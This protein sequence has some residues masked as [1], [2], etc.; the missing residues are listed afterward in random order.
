MATSGGMGHD[1]S[2]L[3]MDHADILFGNDS[4]DDDPFSRKERN[5]DREKESKGHASLGSHL[6]LIALTVF[7]SFGVSLLCHLLEI[8]LNVDHHFLSGI[9]MFKLAMVCAL[10]SMQVLLQRTTVRF[11]RDW[12]MRLC[13]LML[14]LLVISA[15]AK[16]HPKPTSL[17][18]THYLLCSF[19]V[20]ICLSWNAFCFIFVAKYL[21][22]NFWYERALTLSGDA[23][24]HSYTGLLFARVELYFII[25]AL[26]N[27]T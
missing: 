7:M 13:G 23:L 8:E 6:S 3:D 17:E 4:K 16:A 25:T 1:P 21:F 5:R 26:N 27:I 24:G 11:N 15:L 12:F 18:S 10:L 14:D 9:R 22:P 2:D 20:F 19:F